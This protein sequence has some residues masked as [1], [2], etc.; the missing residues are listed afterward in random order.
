MCGEIPNGPGPVVLS[1]GFSKTT[2]SIGLLI[3]VIVKFWQVLG[4]LEEYH[5]I[6]Y[7]ILIISNQNGIEARK[8]TID[9]FKVRWNK[10]HFG[11]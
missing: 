11:Y 7:K 3:R 9:Q 8:I 1:L 2:V 4:K 10:K 5:K 6:G